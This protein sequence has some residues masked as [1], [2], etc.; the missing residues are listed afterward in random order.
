VFVADIT[1]ELILGLDA[2]LRRV[3]GRGVRHVLRMGREEVTLWNPGA[4]PRSSRLTPRSDEVIPGRCENRDGATSG[5]P[6]G[7]ERPCRTQLK[8]LPRTVHCHDISSGPT[9][10]TCHVCK[11]YRP[12]P[13][14][15]WR[16]YRGPLQTSHVGSASGRPR[17]PTVSDTRAL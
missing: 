14:F 8:G 6:G 1:D 16:H 17:P 12:R 7:G 10:G 11:H 15:K 3:S 13:G 5:N 9:K 2:G 4:R